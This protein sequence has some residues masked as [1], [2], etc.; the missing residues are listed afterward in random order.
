MQQKTGIAGY[1]STRD[2][3]KWMYHSA[4]KPRMVNNEEQESA[5]AEQGWSIEYIH[6]AYPKAVVDK[7]G[8]VTIVQS[9][10]D[11]GKKQKK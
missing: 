1:P 6:Q 2:Y 5:L 4:E 7:D 8:N 3:P 9:P 10:D 11:E